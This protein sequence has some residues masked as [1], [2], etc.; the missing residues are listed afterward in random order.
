M[1]IRFIVDSAADIIPAEAAKLNI[2]HVPLEVIF[3]DEQYLDAVNL[4]HAE[5]Y[6]KLE[7][8]KELPRTSQVPPARFAAAFEGTGGAGCTGSPAAGRGRG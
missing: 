2:T 8:H 3:D 7:T 1:A 4:T 5:F 6:Q